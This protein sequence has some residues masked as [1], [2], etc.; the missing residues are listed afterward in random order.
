LAAVLAADASV[1]VRDLGTGEWIGPTNRVRDE[2]ARAVDVAEVVGRS[3]VIAGAMD[4][5]VAIWEAA[6][7]RPGSHPTVLCQHAGPVTVVAA[8]SVGSRVFVVS[9][10]VDRVARRWVVDVAGTRP[11][12]VRAPAHGEDLRM[13]APVGAVAIRIPTGDAPVVAVAADRAVQMWLAHGPGLRIEVNEPVTAIALGD[14]VAFIGTGRG[15]VAIEPASA[16][17]P[18]STSWGER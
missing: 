10:G 7:G 8:A 14:D 16:G 2:P 11:R 1:R 17:G 9:G 3:W 13:A 18:R 15:V 4:G 6:T 12:V 5:T